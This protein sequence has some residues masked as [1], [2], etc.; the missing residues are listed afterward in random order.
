MP[1]ENICYVNHGSKCAFLNL[2]LIGGEWSLYMLPS[3]APL[4]TVHWE[5]ILLGVLLE[6]ELPE[7]W[8]LVCLHINRQALDQYKL[9]EC[10]WWWCVA[11]WYITFILD[12]VHPVK[13][14]KHGISETG[15]VTISM[16]LFISEDVTKL[17]DSFCHII[18][19]SLSHINRNFVNCLSSFHYSHS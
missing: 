19:I 6:V 12:V 5:N 16:S 17:Q 3:L 10:F 1:L 15:I 9:S 18:S 11:L 2:I 14:C 7:A 8:W 13:F 4:A